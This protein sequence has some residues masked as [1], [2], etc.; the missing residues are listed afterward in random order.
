MTL[1]KNLC[2]M[3]LNIFYQEAG[4][5][6][7]H[8]QFQES[9]ISPIQIS[10]INLL[11]HIIQTGI[12]SVCDNRLAHLFEFLQIIY[13]TASKEGAT[14]C[15]TRSAMKSFRVRISIQF[16]K[17]RN[18]KRQICIGQKPYRFRLCKSHDQRINIFLNS[19]F[20]Q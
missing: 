6:I 16:I 3:F 18:M 1:I 12:I 5:S 17:I 2:V 19:A 15:N 8:I 11:P 4:A 20:L 14:I 7:P 10:R 9:L 13:H